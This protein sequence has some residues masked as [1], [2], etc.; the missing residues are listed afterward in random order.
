[1]FDDGKFGRSWSLTTAQ[2]QDEYKL[3]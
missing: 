1:M 2:V 3:G